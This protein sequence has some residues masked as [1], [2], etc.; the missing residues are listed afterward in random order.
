MDTHMQGCDPTEYVNISYAMCVWTFSVGVHADNLPA[1]NFRHKG[2][3]SFRLR[4]RLPVLL[5]FSTLQKWHSAMGSPDH[6]TQFV[7]S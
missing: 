4:P 2:H 1:L 7:H 6:N 3:V 5:W